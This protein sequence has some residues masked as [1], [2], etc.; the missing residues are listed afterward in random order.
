MEYT[1]IRRLSLKVFLGFLGLTALVAIVSVL[2]G[3]FG[4]LQMKVLLTCFAI[5]IASMCS[6]SCAAFI[7][8]RRLAELG[9]AGMFFSILAA[10]L[11]ISGLWLEA[12]GE[13]YW[14]STATVIVAAIAFSH[15]L[16]LFLPQLEFDQRW[17]QQGTAIAIGV[18]AVQIVVAL[19]GEIEGEGYYRVLTAVAIVVGLG[20]LS[21]PVMMKLGK[22][23]EQRRKLV[24]EQI[25][26]GRYQDAA[27]RKYRVEEIGLEDEG[28]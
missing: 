28:H 26:G 4:E 13:V 21:V 14:K 6:M 25:E 8:K 24:L 9:L 23:G 19:W 16:L 11:V 27:G 7:E 15:S 1:D 22:G 17:V 12:G 5:S 20:T 18:L 2:G 10:I 3:E